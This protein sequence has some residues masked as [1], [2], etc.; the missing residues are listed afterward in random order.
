[1][2]E[3]KMSLY[4]G[5]I[6]PLSESQKYTIILTENNLLE[7]ADEKT[8]KII[9][10]REYLRNI[11]DLSPI[12]KRLFDAIPK[13][14]IVYNKVSNT[15][16]LLQLSRDKRFI[17]VGPQYFGSKVDLYK[18]CIEKY[19]SENVNID[20]LHNIVF[21]KDLSQIPLVQPSVQRQPPQNLSLVLAS[22][23]VNPEWKKE[24][25]GKRLPQGQKEAGGKKVG[26]QGL[27]QVQGPPNNPN[28]LVTNEK[29]KEFL[30]SIKDCSNMS[31][32]MAKKIF[33]I[34][35]CKN[36]ESYKRIYRKLALIYHPDKYKGTGTPNI[37]FQ[38]INN[39][40]K[41]LMGDEQAAEA[42]ADIQAVSKEME[43]QIK[44][45]EQKWASQPESQKFVSFSIPQNAPPA[46]S[47]AAL[48]TLLHLA[49]LS[50][51]PVEK[52]CTKSECKFYKKKKGCRDG[53]QCRFLHK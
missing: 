36:K 2:T 24:A 9:D 16:Y 39:A 26:E 27:K 5:K 14:G 46:N 3:Y 17:K 28:I 40:Y 33:D 41:I 52:N 35:N 45:V 37:I 18:Y 30:E 48:K 21:G 29:H 15:Y 49:Q 42:E 4:V 23:S 51:Q 53:N 19:L 6:T 25:G 8:S 44:K 11:K 1:M 43:K 31:E 22:S 13:I 32:E 34:K 12:L 20:E 10:I 7:I 38:C 47:K 50:S